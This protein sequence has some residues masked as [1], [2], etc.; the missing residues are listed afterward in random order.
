[1]NKVVETSVNRAKKIVK[2]Y[3]DRDGTI[4]YGAVRDLLT[5]IMHYC[6][7]CDIHFEDRLEGAREVF[8][9]EDN[10]NKELT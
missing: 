3:V 10:L 8:N 4:N 1:M 9:E 5:D 6:N 7:Y 2:E